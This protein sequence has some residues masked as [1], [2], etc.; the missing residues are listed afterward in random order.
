[1]LETRISARRGFDV[2]NEVP[3]VPQLTGMSCWAA[4][5][6][7]I[8]GWREAIAVEPR[9]VAAGAGRWAEYQAGLHPVDLEDFAR[10]WRFT[11][12]PSRDWTVRDMRELLERHGPVWLG[13]ASPGLHSIVVTGMHGDGTQ[14]GTFARIND[15]WPIDR[16]E[17]YTL[18]WSQL[19]KNLR[20]AADIAGA[21]PQIL[22]A[23]GRRGGASG[24]FRYEKRRVVRSDVQR[25]PAP[26]EEGPMYTIEDSPHH[27]AYPATEGLLPAHAHGSGE[28]GSAYIDT[29][30][31][32]HDPLAGH[33]GSGENLCLVWRGVSAATSA[34]DVV[35]HLHGYSSQVP[36]AAMLR[37]KVGASGLDLSAR[38]RPTLGIVPRGRKI[39]A[40]ER[41]AN[42]G[43][44]A[45]RYTF[46]ALVA[47]GGA[48]LERLIAFALTHLRAASGAGP[49]LEVD[50]LILTAHSGG[51]APLNRLLSWHAN[52]AVCNPHE[53]H[54]F[55]A[56]YGDV[57]GILSWVGARIAADRSRAMSNGTLLGGAL[58]VAYRDGTAAGSARV[59]AALP[60]GTDPLRVAYRAETTT[61]PHGRVATVHGP[62]LLADAR[63]ELTTS[64]SVG[65]SWSG[66]GGDAYGAP[67]GLMEHYRDNPPDP[68]AVATGEVPGDIDPRLYEASSAMDVIRILGDWLRR[69]RR[70][71]VG[72]QN[73]TFFP[74]SAICKL[75]MRFDGVRAEGTGFYIAPNRILTAAHVVVVPGHTIQSMEI[76]PGHANDM[77]TFGSFTVSGASNVVPHPRYRPAS[78]DF[79]LAVVKVGTP[80]PDR[81]HFEIEELRMSPETGIAVCGYAS[82]GTDIDR[83]RQNMDVDTIR[84]LN[85]ETFTYAL[86]AR[87]GTSGAP[88]FYVLGDVIRAV[89]V[90]SRTGDRYHNVGCRLTDQKIRWIRGV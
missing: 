42:P 89:G 7:M 15:P 8:I 58:R 5:A 10:A 78:G 1:M 17:R 82:E 48:G 45:N 81:A 30:T 71:T 85:A 46:P 22:H 23:G 73:P 74:H 55:D 63:A 79:D 32:T 6:A 60:S 13:E 70:F 57:D 69:R 47:D 88:T 43:S 67:V 56:L 19:M 36:D 31:S 28:T 44:N 68:V 12:E 83:N 52:R 29:S 14:D 16:G 65:Q 27:E 20:A 40:E 62:R 64:A 51:G 3:L 33:G 84:D 24:R 25:F 37:G 38:D 75:R 4:G 49:A 2:W 9:E 53:V 86:H 26:E 21:H 54:V 34:V 66:Q 11:V 61:V 90:L 80:P 18:T 35:V 72:V 39:T 77:S 50:R 59:A 76:A 41:R 87:R